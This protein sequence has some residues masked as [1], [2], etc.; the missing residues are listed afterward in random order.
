MAKSRKEYF[1]EQARV[2]KPVRIST[3]LHT[4]L[5]EYCR[6]KGKKINWVAETA[7]KNYLEGIR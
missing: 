1:Q 5:K 3:E 6:I 2:F 7:I 4:E